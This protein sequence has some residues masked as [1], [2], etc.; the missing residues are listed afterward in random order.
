MHLDARGKVTNICKKEEIENRR[1]QFENKI[2][3]WDQF[4]ASQKWRTHLDRR[5]LKS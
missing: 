3:P 4:R 1:F 2:P 5:L